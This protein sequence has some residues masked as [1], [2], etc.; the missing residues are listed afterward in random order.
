MAL[1]TLDARGLKCPMP[2]VKAKKEIDGMAPGDELEVTATD[3]GSVPD[4]QGWV[5]TAKNALLKSQRTE[6][7]DNGKSLYIHVLERK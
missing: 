1:K 3:S 6:T 5:R 7:D 2:I 4:F